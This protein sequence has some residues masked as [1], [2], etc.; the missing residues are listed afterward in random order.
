VSWVGV[1]IANE[2]DGQINPLTK[3]MKTI[4]ATMILWP[5]LVMNSWSQGRI[6]FGNNL[7]SV[8]APIYGPE[9]DYVHFGGDWANAKTGNAATGYPAGGQVYGGALLESFSVSFWA[10]PGSVTDGHLLAPGNVMSL[11]GSG[12]LAGYFP[13][14]SV[15]FPNLPT[16]G[17]ATVQVRVTDPAGTWVFAADSIGRYAAVSALFT[18]NLT[19][20]GSTANG[21]R[22]FSVGWVD[23]STFTPYVP[24][25]NA[26][27]VLGLGAVA[28]LCYSK[29]RKNL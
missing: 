10:A 28:L 13:S 8:R 12:S 15:I 26:G 4:L 11:L 20:L 14:T 21:L 7:P 5:A 23:A 1:P 18:V 27:S 6:T 22:S 25:P 9:L 19:P 29:S 3:S 2:R 17:I 24:E 16:T